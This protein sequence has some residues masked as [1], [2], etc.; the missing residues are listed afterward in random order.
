MGLFKEF[1]EFAVT[2]NVIDTAVGIIVGGAFTPIAQSLVNDLLMPPL[3]LLLGRV[4]FKQLYILLKPGT[5]GATRYATLEAAKEAGA[6]TLN[7][8]MFVN[9]VVSFLILAFA[10]FM[11]VKLINRLRREEKKETPVPEPPPAA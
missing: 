8:G 11:L 9:T 3:G 7:Y 10:V 6:V 1:K 5:D 4:D 2:G